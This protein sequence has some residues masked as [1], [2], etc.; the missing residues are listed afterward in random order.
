MNTREGLR[1]VAVVGGGLTALC[2]AIGFA[3]ALPLATVT[4]IATPLDPAALADRLPAITPPVVAMLDTLGIDEAML[5]AAGAATHRVGE[6]FA[7][8]TP[9]FA[10]GDGEGVASI[11]GAALHQLWLAYGDGPYDALVPAAVLATA[12]RFVPPA[13]DDASLLSL[14]DYTLR[15]DPVIAVPLLE[16]AARKAGVR[17]VPA[18][19]LVVTPAPGGVAAVDADRVEVTADLFVDASGPAA[20]LAPATVEWV[21]WSGTLAADR[22]LLGS[23]AA[24]PSP[25]DVYEAHTLGW[26]A[27]WPL[28]TRTVTALAYRAAATADG[29]AR[30]QMAGEVERIV[31][32]PRRRAAPFAGNVLALGDAAAAV[33]P[34]GWHG[35][36]LALGQLELALALMPARRPEPLL[37]AEY[38]RRA[39]L[40]ADR[41]HAYLAAFYL[42]GPGRGGDFWHP[43]R[44]T[45]PAGELA[46]ALSQFGQRG[47]LPPGEEEMVPASHWS[48]A[49][50]GL[51]I[52]PVRRD[53]IALSVPMASAVAALARLRGAV[54][55]LPAGL[56][57]YPDYL[58]A[59]LRGR[60]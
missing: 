25:T 57:P 23:A 19:R 36:T 1:T 51:G 34:L 21:D 31:V 46:I 55:A 47:T 12:E 11:A 52:R 14:H 16:R 17:I 18:H 58:A 59:I 60:R 54:A 56:P 8:H 53:P 9:P 50:I 38:N 13:T 26:S 30:R 35:L 2:A 7:W 44:K 33:G 37:I 32:A 6:R 45:A 39:T 22:L 42:A 10:V 27:R 41:V 3:R 48:Q 15:L 43:L 49:L 20:L 29:K 5:V 28:A 4:M 24:R 40:R